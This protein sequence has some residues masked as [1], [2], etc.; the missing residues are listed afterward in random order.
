MTFDAAQNLYISRMDTDPAWCKRV[1]VA[2]EK[3]LRDGKDLH[4][5]FALAV[6][7]LKGA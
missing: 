5:A 6:D 1:G 3:F 2:Q 7:L 4:E